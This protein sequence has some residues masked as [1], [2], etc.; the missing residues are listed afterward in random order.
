[1]KIEKSPFIFIEDI[2][3]E[4]CPSLTSSIYKSYIEESQ[5]ILNLKNKNRLDFNYYVSNQRCSNNS[6]DFNWRIVSRFTIDIPLD[7]VLKSYHDNR[8]NRNI[9]SILKDMIKPIDRRSRG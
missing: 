9:S 8:I 6:I 2:S 7:C 5:K 4:P 1:L 3:I